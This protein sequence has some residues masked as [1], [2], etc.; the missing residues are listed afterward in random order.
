[1]VTNVNEKCKICADR[2]KWCGL[3]GNVFLTIFKGYIAIITGSLA[4]MAD[5]I[6]SA[7]DI[8]VSTVTITS[9]T[10]AKKPADKRHP[11]GYGKIEFFGGVFT[12]IVLLSGAS[13]IIV[14]AI[15]HLIS[16]VPQ[17]KPHFVALGAAAISIVVNETLYR[18]M[19][20]GAKRVNSAALEA[21]ALD[22]R[23][24]AFSSIPVFFGLLGAQF[25]FSSL[26]ALAALFVG[27]TV[28]KIAFELLSKNLSG[29]MDRPLPA[30]EIKHIKEVV[31]ATAGVK[32]IDY[33]RTRGM[34]R[35]YM[36]DMQIMVNPKTTIEKSDA[37]VAEVKDA[38]RRE[39]K[40]L[41]DIT[42]VCKAD[43]EKQ[44]EQSH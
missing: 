32:D 38:L 4:L 37:I 24:D 14:S 6:H 30:N 27:I 17:H 16:C 11:Y 22:N 36:A 1:M 5:A 41:E 13:F 3:A 25:G 19:Y 20:C 15:C 18:L 43:V 7:A 23:S 29:L 10:F 40:H 28:G 31:V 9:I 42:I 34:G 39:I 44:E 33:L 26:D 21:E 2:A 8:L 12:G 35:H